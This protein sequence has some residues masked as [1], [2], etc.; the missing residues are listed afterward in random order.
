VA[1]NPA[2]PV[3]KPCRHRIKRAKTR[4]LCGKCYS[5]WLHKVNPS[6]HKR[7][8]RLVDEW[9]WNNHE[10]ARARGRKYTKS[11]SKAVKKDRHLRWKMGISLRDQ[12]AVLR[13]QKK[14]CKICGKPFTERR[15][16]HNDH[17][18]LTDRFRGILCFHCNNGLGLFFDSTKLLRAAL[19]Y[20]L[21]A[22]KATTKFLKKFRIGRN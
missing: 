7:Q 5:A 20:L 22:E 13:K 21:T 8:R 3:P 15:V 12:Q 2:Y 14:R 1:L 16:P 11:L 18:H 19:R 9:Y 10:V 4:G 6:Y 17:N